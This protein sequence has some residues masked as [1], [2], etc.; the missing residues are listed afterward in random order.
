MSC[1]RTVLILPHRPCPTIWSSSS[2]VLTPGPREEMLFAA[3]PSTLVALRDIQVS[4]PG[5]LQPSVSIHGHIHFLSTSGSINVISPPCTRVV[6]QRCRPRSLD[7]RGARR[8]V[9]LVYT[10]H[11]FFFSLYPYV[12]PVVHPTSVLTQS[13]VLYPV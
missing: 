7:D 2:P 3:T 11:A 1:S 6:G 4:S 12:G 9:D 5:R 10:T 13:R 8:T